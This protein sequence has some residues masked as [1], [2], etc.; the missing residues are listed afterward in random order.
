MRRAPL[1]A[2]VAVL[3]LTAIAA[4]RFLTA[5]HEVI[6]STPSA[7]TGG[8]VPLDLASGSELCS[9]Q[10]LFASNAGIARFGATSS[11]AAPAPA[12]DVRAAGETAGRYRSDYHAEAQVPG[13]WS[14]TRQIDVPLTPPRTDT[15]GTLCVRNPGPA[16][17]TLIGTAQGRAAARPTVTIDGTPSEFEFSL[18]IMEPGRH[19]IVSRLGEVTS[20]ASTLKP[21]GA[22]WMWVLSLC[23]LTLAPFAVWRVVAFALDADDA[24]LGADRPGPA[25][26]WDGERVRERFAAVPGWVWLTLAGAV[27]VVWL[28]YWS[29]STHVFQNDE[30]QY[31]FLSRWLQDDVPARLFDVTL[32]GRGLQRL[33]V[34]L[35]AIPAALW[36]APTSLQVAR[37]L[38]TLAY[39]ST[40]IPVYK[41]ARSQRL[42]S[43]W[44]ALPA[45]LAIFVPWGVVTT[46]FLTENLAYP[47]CLWALWAIAE[48]A[49]EPSPWRD[50]RA[51]ALLLVAATARSGLLLLVPVLPVVLAG[52]GLRC[53]TGPLSGRVKQ[54]L[55]DHIVVWAVVALGA[56][57]L[58]SGIGG[59]KQKVAGG[60]QTQLGFNVVDELEKFG[61]Y[62]ARVVIG[63]GFFP[64]AIGLPWV[65]TELVRSRDRR[66]FAFV[67]LIPVTTLALLYSLNTAGPDERYVLYLAPLVLLPATLALARR[68]ISPVGLAIASV[69]LALLVLRVPWNGEQGP[70]GY[71]VSPVEMFYSRAIGLKLGNALGEHGIA[72]LTLV[73]LGLAAG[74]IAIAAVLRWRPRWLVGAPAI[75]L[76]AVVAVSVPAQARYALT[77]YVDTAGSRSGPSLRDRAFVDTT[78]PAG[79][80]VGEFFEGAG[81]TPG[82]Y[83]IWKEVAFYNQRLSSVYSLGPPGNEV[84]PYMRLVSDVSFDARTGRISSSEPLPDYLVIPTPVG[85][86]RVRGEILKAPPHIAVAL[87]KVARPATMAWSAT[88]IDA[89][90]AMVEGD[91]ATVRFYGTGLPADPQCAAFSLIGPPDRPE[92]WNLDVAGSRPVTGSVMAGQTRNVTVGLPRLAERGSIDVRVSGKGVRVAGVGVGAH[93]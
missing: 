40:A 2:F 41:L 28:S 9:D 7:Y 58:V 88:G 35:L 49:S 76:V 3:A 84:L 72:P 46:G 13:G 20:H 33:E 10:I 60:Y 12:L 11:G 90:G 54:V 8:T 80:S 62:L 24:A 1:I 29:L 25:Y 32:Y 38:N 42:S 5:P 55:R 91:A 64:A 44:A 31:M 73:G 59:L 14:G 77:R 50:L 34:W 68:E 74:G 87:I 15:M 67:L 82:F 65:A 30:Y 22:W 6:A 70:F 69:L 43:R 4:G 26:A 83:P 63:T 18:R 17:V 86:A 92:V 45:A 75:V 71:F 78:V 37:I 85:A 51:L 93:C 21:F 39:V 81:Q 23:L 61:R 16:A 89:T 48:A 66:R 47:A 36:D 27:A 19:T 53:N 79:A 52:T 56:L 57:V